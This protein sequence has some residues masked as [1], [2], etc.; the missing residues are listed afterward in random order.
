MVVLIPLQRLLRNQTRRHVFWRRLDEIHVECSTQV[1]AIG[2]HCYRLAE[3]EFQSNR[4][5]TAAVP[6]SHLSVLNIGLL[7]TQDTAG[8]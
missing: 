5:R 6:C 2:Y 3:L 4:S 7:E 8:I 1:I